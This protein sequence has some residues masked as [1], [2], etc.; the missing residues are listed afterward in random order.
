L[1]IAKGGKADD[2][3]DAKVAGITLRRYTPAPGVEF[4]WGFK[5][6][7]FLAT[8]GPDAA[9]ELL[10]RIGGNGPKPAWLSSL[11]KQAAVKRVSTIR[12]LDVARLIAT[13]AP[14][15]APAAP[16]NGVDIPAFLEASGLDDLVSIGAVSGFGTKEWSIATCQFQI[17][18]QRSFRTFRRQ[19]T[20]GRRFE[21]D[22]QH[23]GSCRCAPARSCAGL[24]KADRTGGKGKSERGSAVQ[25]NV[26][27]IG[28]G[29]RTSTRGRH[30][31]GVRRCLDLPWHR[32]TGP[33]QLSGLLLT[34]SLK[35]KETLVKLQ[36][37]VLGMTKAQGAKLPF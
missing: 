32:R 31:G 35:N 14:T 27:R 26:V 4:H 8:I 23:G 30:L 37:L 12:Y 24:Q 11:T 33:D 6:D 28:A 10:A 29:V 16:D 19:A 20:H 25:A 15:I 34:V 18:A 22:S 36:Q 5:G 7:Y 21:T 3:S 17:F 2:I 9:A 1:A 13:I